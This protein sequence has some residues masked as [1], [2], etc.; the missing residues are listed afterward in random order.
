M[1]LQG[2][3]KNV[4]LIQK[5]IKKM[6]AIIMRLRYISGIMPNPNPKPIPESL[7]GHR[8]RV[9]AEQTVQYTIALPASIHAWAKAKGATWLRERLK[10]LKA[11]DDRHKT[12]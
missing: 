5:C 2:K 3:Y 8:P 11:L 4:S 9:S 6:I 1:H 10:A 7:R 12:A